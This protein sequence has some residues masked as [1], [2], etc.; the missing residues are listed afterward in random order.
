MFESSMKSLFLTLVF[1]AALSGAAVAQTP[2]PAPSAEAPASVDDIVVVARR[3]GLPIWTVDRGDSTVILVGSISGVPR[4]YEWRPEALEQATLRSQRVLY[5]IEGR[6][7]PADVLRL[8]WRIRTITRLPDGRTIADYASP[9]LMAQLEA[10]HAGERS[11]N[12]R[13]EPPLIQSLDLMDR[14]GLERRGRAVVGVVSDKARRARIPGDAVGVVRGDELIDGLLTAP[15]ETY[16]A[17]LAM[18]VEAA[19]AG[20]EGAAKRLDDWSHLRVAAV[21]ANPLDQALNLCWPSGDPEVAPML[22]QK[23]LE[24]TDQALGQPGVTLAVAPLRVL[25]EPDG[26]LDRLEAAGLDPRG[27]EWRPVGE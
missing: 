3:A 16:L 6:A 5:P 13:R 23:W 26:V 17:C 15:P 20:P 1:S 9:E 7:S 21:L 19:Q 18:T 12:W 10:L 11:Q 24:A 27:P 4:N 8:I 22:R 2:P 14:T 25:A